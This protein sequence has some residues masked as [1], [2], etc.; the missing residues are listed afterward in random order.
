MTSKATG[1]RLTPGNLVAQLDRLV[2]DGKLGLAV[3]G[4]PDSLALL[5]LA[6]EA[7]PG[8]VR[9][10]TVDHGLRSEAAEEALA[11][12]RICAQ[13]GVPHDVLR[14]TVSKSASI[15][16]QARAARYQALGEWAEHH[17]L[18]AV[19]T[20]H[21][22]D[23]QA[24]TLL[25]RLMRGSGIGGLVGIRAQRPLR[26]SVLLVRPL[27]GIRKSDLVAV[28]SAAGLDAADDPSN[29]DPRHDR[30]AVRALLAERPELDP[31]RLA[32]SAAAL[33][34]AEEA[35]RTFADLECARGV[36]IDGSGFIYHPQAPREIRRRVA[37]KL[38][39]R[40]ASQAEVRGPDLE[41][42]LDRLEVGGGGTLAGVN[43][44]AE[45]G[46]WRFAPAPQ[47]T[48]LHP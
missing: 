28:V 17:G 48:K 12:G 18:T 14:V 44:R 23:D 19:A 16:A 10:A 22:A 39:A 7:R 38:I 20:A 25:M 29:R 36:T 31:E 41:R 47:R 30:T 33:A 45:D 6:A 1:A 24:E 40:L 2:P 43:V 27:L 8:R 34:D 42:L 32:R 11:T 21:H 46:G 26:G 37:R 15:Q 9:A 5:L 35:L 13:L 3:S 4:G